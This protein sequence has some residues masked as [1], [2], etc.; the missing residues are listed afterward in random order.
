MLKAITKFVLQ[1]RKTVQKPQQ[2]VVEGDDTRD[3]TSGSEDLKQPAEPPVDELSSQPVWGKV[4]WY[5]PDKRYG[6]VELSDV[7]GRRRKREL[8]GDALARRY[9]V[10]KHHYLNCHR[11][12]LG[13]FH[14]SWPPCPAS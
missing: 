6:F 12:P 8:F 3:P 2:Q 13:I 1:R 4:K 10:L 14:W 9:S 5:N 11:Y 7:D